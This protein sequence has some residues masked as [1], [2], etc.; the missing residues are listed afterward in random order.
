[1]KIE[2]TM[3]KP[4]A[5][6]SSTANS[7]DNDIRI[8][9]P[10]PNDILLKKQ[11]H[12]GN[13][14][15][16]EFVL[17][18]TRRYNHPSASQ[19]QKRAIREEIL[20]MVYS[21]KPPGRFLTRPGVVDYWVVA[22]DDQIT[23][24]LTSAFSSAKQRLISGKEPSIGVATWSNS[25][26]QRRQHFNNHSSSNPYRPFNK[27]ASEFSAGNA[28][29]RSNSDPAVASA[30]GSRRTNEILAPSE[31][32]P[33]GFNESTNKARAT[34]KKSSE[35][36]SP[37]PAVARRPVTRSS[38]KESTPRSSK[39]QKRKGDSTKLPTTAKKPKKLHQSEKKKPSNGSRYSKARQPVSAPVIPIEEEE[40]KYGG[41]VFSEQFSDITIQCGRGNSKS[42]SIPAHK[43]MLA[44]NSPIL[45]SLL[46][47]LPS[48]DDARLRIAYPSRIV[49]EMLQFIYQTNSCMSSGATYRPSFDE[50]SKIIQQDVHLLFGI[51]KE[52]QLTGFY[53]QIFAAYYKTLSA[54]NIKQKF[55]QQ[56]RHSTASD[57]ES[58]AE[59]A[60]RVCLSFLQNNARAILKDSNF[61]ALSQSHADL[62]ARIVDC[63]L[64]YEDD[65]DDQF[66]SPSSSSSDGNDDNSAGSDNEDKSVVDLS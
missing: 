22:T 15:L 23:K 33:A 57:S 37:S 43:A 19:A 30:H 47:G 13:Q 2:K 49:R 52:F 14:M 28:R 6:Y 31:R 39:N 20:A 48:G 64:G 4:Y 55:L 53:Q 58:G 46:E 18:Y 44:N 51:S 10:N 59:E 54:E 27:N 5:A 66:D 40:E 42:G 62:W 56:Y 50:S 24:K 41:V 21:Q 3:A 45:R 34:E 17:D 32:I 8:Y 35:P 60:L 29:R 36:V 9:H 65:D 7:S 16:N 1:M 11:S 61:V 63:T 25:T 12:P 26:T 38:P